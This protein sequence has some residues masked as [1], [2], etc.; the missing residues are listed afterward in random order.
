MACDS[1]ISVE[2]VKDMVTRGSL[3]D[4]QLKYEY[5]LLLKQIK[6]QTKRFDISFVVVSVTNGI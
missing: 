1:K 4:S 2:K 6:K 3:N 5:I